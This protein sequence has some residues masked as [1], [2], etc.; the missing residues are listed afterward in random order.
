MNLYSPPLSLIVA[1]L[2]VKVT[3]LYVPLIVS[4]VSLM[5]KLNSL[6]VSTSLPVR[7]LDTSRLPYVSRVLVKIASTSSLPV[8]V[9]VSC[10][11][12]VT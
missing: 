8:I 11:L 4:P 6:F 2:L 10:V 3:P 12:V 1:V 9:P 7:T 5:V